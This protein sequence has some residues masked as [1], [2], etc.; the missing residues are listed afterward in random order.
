MNNSEKCFPKYL[1]IV[2]VQLDNFLL[3]CIYNIYNVIGDEKSK[4][5]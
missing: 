2:I 4:D 1:Y 3:L 5:V